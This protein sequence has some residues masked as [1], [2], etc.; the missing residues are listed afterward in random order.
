MQKSGL[1]RRSMSLAASCT[2]DSAR[3]MLT[4]MMATTATAPRPAQQEAC[5]R[6]VLLP[7]LVTAMPAPLIAM[8]QQ[9]H[10]TLPLHACIRTAQSLQTFR[11]GFPWTVMPMMRQAMK[12]TES[13]MEQSL[14]LTGS[15]MATRQ[16]TSTAR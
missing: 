4:A 1:A 7:A 14:Q 10:A 2:A 9:T 12:T 6:L 5:A 13:Y 3:Q 15:A 16:Y 11:Y 8:K